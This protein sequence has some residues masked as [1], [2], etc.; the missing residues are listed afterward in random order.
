MAREATTRRMTALVRQWESSAETKTEWVRRHGVALSTFSYWQRRVHGTPPVEAGPTFAAVRLVSELN[1]GPVVDMHL[2]RISRTLGVL[3]HSRCKTIGSTES[4]MS[5]A[6][7]SST[8][9]LPY[10]WRLIVFSRFTCRSTGPL[11]HRSVTAVG[12]PS[13]RRP[14][15]GSCHQTVERGYRAALISCTLLPSYSGRYSSQFLDRASWR[16]TRADRFPSVQNNI[17]VDVGDGRAGRQDVARC[18]TCIMR[19]SSKLVYTWRAVVQEMRAT[20]LCREI[21]DCSYNRTNR[22]IAV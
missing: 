15:A 19:M 10:I 7:R 18:K 22:D 20:T 16:S 14:A 8:P 1:G 3:T 6:R 4:G 5:R 2:N 13:F 11:L 21:V 9:A 17:A 12:L